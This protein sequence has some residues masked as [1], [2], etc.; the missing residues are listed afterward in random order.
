MLIAAVADTHGQTEAIIACLTLI[1]PDYLLFAGDFY[2]DGRTIANKLKL[3]ATIVPGNCDPS[4]HLR[5]EQVVDLQKHRFLL[6][7]GHQHG[8]K[9]SLQRLYYHARELEV[10]AVVFG[11]THKPFCERVGDIWMINPGS[12]ARPRLSDQASYALIEVDQENINP[13]IRRIGI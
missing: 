5:P 12:P 11:H 2:R 4:S 13:T 8:V 7:H 10:A 6:I 3:A 9:T 1:K